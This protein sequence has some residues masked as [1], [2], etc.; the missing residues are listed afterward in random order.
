MPAAPTVATLFDFESAYES[1]LAG[2]LSNVNTAWQ[3]LT[4]QSNAN[5]A[6]I[7]LT[8]RIMCSFAVQSANDQRATSNGVGYY[9]AWTGTMTVHVCTARDDA[10]QNHGL[11][12]GTVRQAMLERT[13]VFNA[14]AVPY[15]QTAD[16]GGGS[17]SQGSDTENQEII[18]ILTYPFTFYVPAASFP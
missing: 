13:Q 9:A 5:V 15:Y 6:P 14:N 18:T 2:Y 17:S 10:S 1:A 4:P 11:M 3:V 7:L 8:P 12:R 16:I